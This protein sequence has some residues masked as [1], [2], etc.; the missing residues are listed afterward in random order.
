MRQLRQA[1]GHRHQGQK[2]RFISAA[3][4]FLLDGVHMR[5]GRKRAW[6]QFLVKSIACQIGKPH[7]NSSA[8]AAAL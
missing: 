1:K 4:T 2:L 6:N 7:D 3:L 8:P 5:R